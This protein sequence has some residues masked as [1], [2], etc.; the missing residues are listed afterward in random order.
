MFTAEVEHLLGFRDA[1]DGRAGK[2][3]PLE[4]EV[5]D[6]QHLE[7]PHSATVRFED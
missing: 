7:P 1:A 5:E 6:R 4:D 3:A 2:A